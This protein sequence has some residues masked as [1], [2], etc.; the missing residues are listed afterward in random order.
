MKMR[1]AQPSVPPASSLPHHAA[2]PPTTSILRPTIRRRLLA[3]LLVLATLTSLASTAAFLAYLLLPLA[4]PVARTAYTGLYTV[5][6]TGLGIAEACQILGVLLLLSLWVTRT[7]APRRLREL[8]VLL[9]SLIP[10]MPVLIFVVTLYAYLR[11]RRSQPPLAPQ[12]QQA[13]Q[14]LKDQAADT[15]VDSASN[16]SSSSAAAATHAAAPRSAGGS[17]AG[18]VPGLGPSVPE[19]IPATTAS[20]QPRPGAPRS[21]AQEAIRR[22]VGPS[23]SQVLS[24]AAN[25]L[26][27]VAL[28][29]LLL[30]AA[31]TATTVAVA[32][33]TLPGGSP[34]SPAASAVGGCSTVPPVDPRATTLIGAVRHTTEM[35]DWQT[36]VFA[37][38]NDLTTFSLK[39]PFGTAVLLR[40]NSAGRL[41]IHMTFCATG[42]DDPA[43]DTSLPVAPNLAGT[44]F[45]AA[46]W[47][48]DTQNP[49]D[50]GRVLQ[51]MFWNGSLVHV[52]FL[53]IASS[54]TPHACPP[55]LV[56]AVSDFTLSALHIDAAQISETGVSTLSF[57]YVAQRAGT[58][59]FFVCIDGDT[60]LSSSL[61]L[62][63][64]SNT[65][66]AYQDMI[67]DPRSG[68]CLTCQDYGAARWIV[69]WNQQAVAQV[70][71]V[72]TA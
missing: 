22:V 56:R 12:R 21:R 59:E 64:G 39:Q 6:I 58:L 25:T 43:E 52:S 61:Q 62:A 38:Q 54:D 9:L 14:D 51:T 53:M 37:P 2:Y 35:S 46:T 11:L 32:G 8:V 28:V 48:Y 67:Q 72:V 34:S 57:T 71:F 26:A 15:F 20:A 41:T 13:A 27:A 68:N 24:G 50:V 47:F 10:Y 63:V 7:Y 45:L 69:V 44:W 36:G 4:T 1:P 17:G 33:V 3:V 23:T 16:V 19:A 60:F 30:S 55:P 49:Q 66:Q 42:H 29:A 40:T 31:A 5:G 70:P 18:T 65:Y